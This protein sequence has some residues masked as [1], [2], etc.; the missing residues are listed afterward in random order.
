MFKQ[1]KISAQTTTSMQSA[2]KKILFLLSSVFLLIGLLYFIYWVVYA[3]YFQTTDNAYVAGNV[4]PVSAQITG[5]VIELNV[6][7]TQLVQA[8]QSLIKLDP[9]DSAV[10]LDQ[11]KANLALALRQTQQYFINNR[12]L[13]AIIQSR[14][15]DL[16]KAKVDLQRRQTAIKRGAISQE[17]LTHA[18]DSFNVANAALLQSQA[19]WEANLALTHR[20]NS[21][22]HPHVRQA[23]AALRQAYLNYIRSTIRAPLSGYV[24]KRAVQIGQRIIPGQILLAIIPLNQIW[25]DANFKEKQLGKIQIGQQVT[26]TSDLYGAKVKYHGRITGFSAGTG[27]AFAL[28]PPQNATGNW[29][30]VVQRLPVRISLDEQELNAH[31]LRIGL[32]MKV[33]V[34]TR[35]KND[36]QVT[37]LANSRYQT[38]IFN[39]LMKQADNIINDIVQENILRSSDL[40]IADKES[41]INIKLNNTNANI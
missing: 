25:V 38:T 21:I 14:Q 13:Q 35:N 11:A 37:Q 6:D 7:D 32:S 20:T 39:N 34:D 27:S 18:E 9:T 17:E 24:A 36:N 10:A 12:E 2:R 40:K 15:S 29:I 1:L 41:F 19:H 22:N 5:N 31:P 33:T 4:I 28:L 26:L 16:Q 3:R 8:G 30:K 23:M